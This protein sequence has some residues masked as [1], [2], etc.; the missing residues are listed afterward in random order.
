MNNN[1]SPVEMTIRAV[2]LGIVLS[3]I[4]AGAN[5]YLG[6]FAG[7][8]VSASIPAAVISMALLSVMG[9]GSILE[10]NLVQTAASAGE[11]LAAGVI[12]TMP[13]LVILGFWKEFDFLQVTMI[14]G[15]GGVLGVL[16]TIPLRRSLIIDAKL[17]FPEG[18]ATAEVLRSGEQGGAGVRYIAQAG[19]VG[20]LFKFGESGLRIWDGVFEWGVR[21]GGTVL[22]FGSNLSPALLSV[23]YIVGLNVAV[24]IVLGGAFNWYLAIPAFAA[25][26]EWPLDKTTGAALG[27]VDG[28]QWIWAEKTR[29][30]GVGGMLIGGLW[31]IFKI[32]GS[33][34]S[35]FAAGV[36]AYRRLAGAPEETPREERDIPMNWV[37]AMIVFSVIPLLL[38]Y[39]VF[40]QNLAV[41]GGYGGRHGHHRIS[42]FRRR[43]LHGRSRRIV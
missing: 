38:L 16:F 21:A 40:V 35:G 3:V 1:N 27:A 26:H 9:R 5:A 7:M 14:A 32:R 24:L 31:T 2:I 37:A 28:A 30:I 29:Y 12:F 20:A 34:F 10:N 42:L 33:L 11:S 25:W 15:F 4:L 13:A 41:S 23:G 19:V 6:L 36:K 43:R 22:Y 8:T 39:E 17:K 18:V